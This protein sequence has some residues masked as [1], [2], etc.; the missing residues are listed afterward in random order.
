MITTFNQT[1]LERPMTATLDEHH[2][3]ELTPD[4]YL[5]RELA[6]IEF[7]RRVLAVAQDPSVPLLERVK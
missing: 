4:T 5:N 6:W 2:L 7:N 3:P 1:L